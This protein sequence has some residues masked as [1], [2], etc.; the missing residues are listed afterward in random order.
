MLRPMLILGALIAA[1]SG[2]SSAQARVRVEAA[3]LDGPRQLQEQTQ[4]AAIRDYLHAWQTIGTALDQERVDL[5]D[6]DFAGTAREKLA[7][8][9]KQQSA[10]GIHTRYQDKSHD[11]QIVFYSPD[12]LSIQLTDDVEYDV[13][14]LEGDKLQTTQHVRARYV[15]VLTPA[16]VRWRVRVLQARSE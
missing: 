8:V 5:L 10:V 12:G 2:T 1:A 16:E 7:D 11:L 13:Q 15:A 4:A 14:V 3:H 6:R 9:I